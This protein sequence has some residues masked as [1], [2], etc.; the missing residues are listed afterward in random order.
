MSE[1]P[2]F[3]AVAAVAAM[4]ACG[5]GEEAAP[6][7]AETP[8]A[9]TAPAESGASGNGVISGIIAYANGDPDAVIDMTDDPICQFMHPNGHQSEKVVTAAGRLANVFVYI[10]SGLRGTYPPPGESVLLD[11]MGCTYSPRVLGIQVGQPLVIRNSDKTLHKVHA[12]PERNEEFIKVQPFEGLEFET[13]FSVAEVMVP[14]KCDEHP[15]MSS[16]IGVVDHPYYAVSGVDGSFSI[17]G[18]PAGEYELEAWH[19]ELGTRTM[20][21]SLAAD[22]VVE[23][24]FDFSPAA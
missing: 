10:K 2:V 15:W 20:T 23:A 17:A 9:Q 4:V 5:G 14:V 8:P 6:T 18:L 1:K 22:G 7:A 13:S 16:Y 3:L 19:E 21:V 12:K 24:D 11:Q